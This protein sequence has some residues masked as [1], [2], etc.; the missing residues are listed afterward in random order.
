MTTEQR[1]RNA[2]KSVSDCQPFFTAL[3]YGLTVRKDDN[4]PT[5]GTDGEDVVYNEKFVDSLRDD[6]LNGVVLHEILHCAFEHLWRRKERD[7]LLWNMATDY[8]IN[9]TVV[10]NFP[11]PKGTLIDMRYVGLSA[12]EIY[13]LLKKRFKNQNKSGKGKSSKQSGK[14]QGESTPQEQ[15]WCDKKEWDGQG[16]KEKNPIKKMFKKEKSE[17]EK[18]RIQDNWAKKLDQA[19]HQTQGDI[20]GNLKRI[21]EKKYYI[22]TINWSE[23]V[24]NLLS[25]DETDY[26]FSS[27]DR[28]FLESDFYL[29][30]LYSQDKLKDVVFAYDTSGSISQEDLHAYVQETINLFEN[31]YNLEGWITVCD[32]KVHSFQQIDLKSADFND[33]GFTGW[34]GTD[35]IPVFDE[36]KKRQLRPKALFYFTDTEGSFPHEAPEFPVYWLVRSQIMSKQQS[37]SMMSQVPFGTVI[38]FMSK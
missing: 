3:A 19:I 36:I 8:A 7:P 38:P 13:E 12:D 20:P 32:A 31:F 22:P 18:K 35:F 26:D 1:I 15:S 17:A 10:D 16:D 9:P 27:P 33:F 11:L 4:V 28:R 24:K 30:N 2:I 34:G 6:E 37:D 29:P 5:M 25:E 23:L 14:G 21:I